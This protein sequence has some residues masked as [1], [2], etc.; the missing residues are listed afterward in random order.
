MYRIALRLLAA[1]PKPMKPKEES[2]N[3]SLDF[4][5]DEVSRQIDSQSSRIDALNEKASII[6]GF[7]G[8]ILTLLMSSAATIALKS[9]ITFISICIAAFLAAVTMVTSALAYGIRKYRL[10]PDPES[11]AKGYLDQPLDVVK[12][13]VLSN[14]IE[15]YKKNERIVDRIARQILVCYGYG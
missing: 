2:Q 14:K 7:S 4:I 15:T 5:F 3:H 13:Q 12:L 1:R 8:V 10:D 9:W 6:L 11:L